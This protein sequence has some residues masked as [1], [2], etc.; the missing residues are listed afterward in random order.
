MI[1]LWKNV[2]RLEL[3]ASSLNVSL[4]FSFMWFLVQHMFESDDFHSFIC[5]NLLGA[6]L[7][8]KCQSGACQTCNKHFLFPLLPS[9]IPWNSPS[10]AFSF[11]MS[12]FQQ[13]KTGLELSF[14]QILSH[15]IWKRPVRSSNLTDSLPTMLPSE[16][17][18]LVS[19]LHVS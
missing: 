14:D 13:R 12:P 15:Y 7:R 19:H 8:V 2:Y 5:I 17:Y 18:S 10:A 11:F 3:I 16:L 1:F 9:S 6:L 4:I